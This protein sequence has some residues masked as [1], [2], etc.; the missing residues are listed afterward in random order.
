MS[1]NAKHAGKEIQ[2]MRLGYRLVI[3][4]VDGIRS[5]V[6][7][8]QLAF[9]LI[10]GNWSNTFIDHKNRNKLDN[11]WENLRPASKQQ[12][13]FNA[14][15]YAS[16]TSEFK[17]VRFESETNKWSARIQCN[18][19]TKFLGLFEL[20]IEAASVYD[21]AATSLHGEFA[22]LNGVCLSY[23]PA[24]SRIPE[25]SSG[26]RGVYPHSRLHGKWVAR[27]RGKHLGLFSS[28]ELAAAAIQTIPESK[29]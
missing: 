26:I 23:T 18:R 25:G 11:S 16:A 28:K 27:A 17:G 10:T 4:I 22:V 6:P 13:N 8:N 12:N 14:G 7:A 5:C 20:E 3:L 9:A 15:K 19:V 21:K 29:E 1:W 24:R 2:S